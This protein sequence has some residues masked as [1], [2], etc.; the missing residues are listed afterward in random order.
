[1]KLSD[2]I[3]NET[4]LFMRRNFIIGFV[5]LVL[6]CIS[7]VVKIRMQNNLRTSEKR[8]GMITAYALGITAKVAKS[9]TMKILPHCLPWD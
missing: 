8:S 1:M 4:A 2:D 5:L 7:I 6:A 3:D 9:D